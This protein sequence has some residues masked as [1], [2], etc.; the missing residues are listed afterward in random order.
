MDKV[1]MDNIAIC[2]TTRIF[3]EKFECTWDKSRDTFWYSTLGDAFYL[4][5]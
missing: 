1:S 2:L 5:L 4:D 3:I